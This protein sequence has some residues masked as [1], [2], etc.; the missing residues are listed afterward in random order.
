M[1]AEVTARYLRASDALF[2]PQQASLGD[3]VPSKL[4]DCAAVG[5]PLI[6]A[7]DGETRRLAE[8]A[9]VAIAVEPGDAG[10]IAAA[11]RELRQDPGLGR[12]LASNGR[13]FAA[14]YLRER[15][16]DRLV[17]LAESVV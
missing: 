1:P 3:F 9:E 2:V 14:D 8:E 12:R 10:Q 6:V 7:A 4:Y 15:Q 17:D 16:A 11:V 13:L 5:R